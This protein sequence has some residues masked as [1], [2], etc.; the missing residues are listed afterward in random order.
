MAKFIFFVF[1]LYMKINSINFFNYNNLPH[2]NSNNNASIN[3]NARQNG[4]QNELKSLEVLGR[5]QVKFTGSNNDKSKEFDD[6]LYNQISKKLEL[7][8]DENNKFQKIVTK[9]MK[10]NNF[11]STEEFFSACDDVEVVDSFIKIV[12]TGLKLSPEKNDIFEEFFLQNLTVN[13]L[14]KAFEED[15]TLFDNM[16][17]FVTK[18]L[19]N[20]LVCNN[21]VEKF[22]LDEQEKTNIISHLNKLENNISPEEVAYDITEDY[23]LSSIDDFNYVLKTIKSRD[24][25]CMDFLADEDSVNNDF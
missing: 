3:Q 15:S 5:S 17:P 12:E 6:F 24:K 10:A 8:D 25:M 4:I 7:S 21:L 19:E 18:S 9:F 11:S 23:N 20:Y 13:K 16:M 22:N 2:K 14:S 1:N